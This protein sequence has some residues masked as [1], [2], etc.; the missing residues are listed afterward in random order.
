MPDF[1][2][3][4][5]SY[6]KAATVIVKRLETVLAGLQLAIAKSTGIAFMP[7]KI[8]PKTSER[9]RDPMG[10]VCM[11]ECLCL[12]KYDGRERKLAHVQ[13]LE[14]LHVKIHGHDKDRV[15]GHSIM[16]LSERIFKVVHA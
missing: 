13:S 4:G 8:D 1:E 7:L 10:G 16:R 12:C 5:A 11:K 15:H 3:Q 14:I 9:E 6:S 2:L